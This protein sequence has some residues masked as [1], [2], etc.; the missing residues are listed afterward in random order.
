[1]DTGN[2][3]DIT[4][5][6]VWILKDYTIVYDEEGVL[7]QEKPLEVVPEEKEEVIVPKNP[8]T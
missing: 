6:A 3:Q 1:M 8:V 4:L 5:E 7:F 2:A